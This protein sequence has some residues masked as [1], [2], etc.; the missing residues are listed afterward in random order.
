MLRLIY[1]FL[2]SSVVV[3]VYASTPSAQQL[4]S[5]ISSHKVIFF[6]EG[7]DPEADSV[8]QMIA[9]FYV[10]QF[11][12]FQDPLA[13]YF[14]LMS[15]DSSLAMGIGGAVRMRGY[16]D[17]GGAMPTS[18]FIPYSIP[19]VPD[20]SA[21][22]AL[23][24]TPAGT[25]L[26]FKVIG[27]DKRWGDYQLYIEANFNGYQARDFHL[28][29]AYA[30]INDWTVGYAVS[31]FSDPEAC[32][33]TVDAQGPNNKVSNTAVLLR[34]MHTW[35]DRWSL[36]VSVETPSVPSLADGSDVTTVKPYIPDFAVFGQCAVGSGGHVRLAG[37]IRPLSYRDQVSA[38]VRNEVGWGL[39]LS[40]KFH[41]VSPLVCY[42]SVNGGF[43]IGGIGGD[44][45]L[46]KYDLVADPGKDGRMYAPASFGW[47][48]GLQYYFRPNLFVSGSWGQN[49][50]YPR[51][52]VP[53]DE[54][55]YGVY[56]AVN[57]FWNPTPRIQ[58]GAELNVGE[59][60]NVGGAHR[61]ARRA[62]AMCQFSF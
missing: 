31:T 1:A 56:G 15:K 8:R 52:G 50:Y 40:A 43:G 53:D 38:C 54:Y 29:K 24:T 17:W 27:R 11:R 4:D 3:S 48:A 25:C 61:W 33:P 34:W 44:L 41:I 18:G 19:I 39:Q 60:R 36:A 9:R 57:V 20:P 58:V 59:R 45:Q 5:I 30:I 49:H 12:H 2:I 26:F 42:S 14:L 32:P 22:R 13:P 23:G 16:Y 35:R 46:G 28:K 10:D 55:R 62:G 51:V 47:V 37:I 21:M 6:G 7:D